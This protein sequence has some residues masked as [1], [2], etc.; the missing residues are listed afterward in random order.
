[1]DQQHWELTQSPERCPSGLRSTLGKRVCRQRYRGFESLSLRT[2]PKA[3]PAKL[4]GFSF[5][6]WSELAHGTDRKKIPRARTKRA[7]GA[8]RDRARLPPQD[9]A[10]KA[11]KIPRHD[12]FER[13]CQQKTERV[14]TKPQVHR[15]SWVILRCLGAYWLVLEPTSCSSNI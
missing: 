9:V 11:S 6:L 4:V 2:I 15:L 3:P 14:L 8:E 5:G 13:S 1:L 10:S 7:V 12:Q